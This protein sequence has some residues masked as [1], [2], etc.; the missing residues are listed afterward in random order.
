M[1]I[2]INDQEVKNCIHVMTAIRANGNQ[3]ED[4]SPED[5]DVEI[6]WHGDHVT[7]K[8]EIDD[9]IF[10]FN[11]QRVVDAIARYFLEYHYITASLLITIDYNPD[12]GGFS[13][14]IELE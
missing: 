2:N 4:C 10:T 6:T 12:L 5:T 11:H 14:T 7:A 9:E 3:F 1:I 8:G 13:A